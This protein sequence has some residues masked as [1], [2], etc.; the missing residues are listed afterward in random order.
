MGKNAKY[1][2]SLPQLDEIVGFKEKN[3]VIIGS[4]NVSCGRT[5]FM[6][7]MAIENAKSGIKTLFC[8]SEI[9]PINFTIRIMNNLYNRNIKD[10]FA[11]DAGIVNETE[12]AA[13]IINLQND[14]TF[15]LVY[16]NLKLFTYDMNSPDTIVENIE[17]AVK[18]VGFEAV[19]VDSMQSLIFNQPDPFTSLRKV[20]F[21]LKN[22]AF[23]NNILVIVGYSMKS[24]NAVS[25]YIPFDSFDSPM[26]EVADIAILFDNCDVRKVKIEVTKNRYVGNTGSIISSANFSSGRFF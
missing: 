14:E 3:F 26:K 7:Q 1:I 16:K 5:S 23:N 18:D 17:N 4:T 8:S 6:L 25:E 22:M 12:C 15:K 21:N 24:C 13:C 10:Q 9:S 19:F 2:S 20:S 11:D